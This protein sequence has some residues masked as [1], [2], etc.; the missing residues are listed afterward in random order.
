MRTAPIGI[1]FRGDTG[2]LERISREGRK[3]SEIL[4]PFRE[5]YFISGEINSTVEDVPLKLQELKDWLQ[6]PVTP[7]RVVSLVAAGGRGAR[8]DRCRQPMS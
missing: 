8:R 2:A 6:T 4:G 1:R 3:L 5:R 7:D